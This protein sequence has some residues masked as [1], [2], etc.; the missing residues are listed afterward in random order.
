[1]GI[2]FNRKANRSGVSDK[3]LARAA[4]IYFGVYNDAEEKKF[5]QNVAAGVKQAMGDIKKEEQKQKKAPEAKSATTTQA[6]KQEQS[7]QKKKAPEVNKKANEPKPQQQEKTETVDELIKES[8]ETAKAA[9]VP[10][11]EILKTK[12]DLD[13]YFLGEGPIPD[14]LIE[15]LKKIAAKEKTSFPDSKSGTGK[16][17]Q[18]KV[19]LI[20]GRVDL[21]EGKHQGLD[22]IQI[23]CLLHFL[24]SKKLRKKLQAV[25]YPAGVKL[26]E[27]N[28]ISDGFDFA[29]VIPGGKVIEFCSIPQWNDEKKRWDNRIKTTDAA[30]DITKEQQQNNQ[31]A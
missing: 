12:D 9:G 24:E 19:D 6:P 23:D 15:D 17:V 8:A 14:S 4:A 7:Q 13:K 26:A 21:I 11:E 30:K 29:F 1:M 25:D 28:P 3:E 5:Q 16:S 2:L 22:E 10:D 18:E 31:A 27:V 20:K